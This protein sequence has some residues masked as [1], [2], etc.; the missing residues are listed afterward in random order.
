MNFYKKQK[1]LD[2]AC[3]IVF[4][5][6]LTIVL[7]LAYSLLSR[8][9]AYDERKYKAKEICLEI[10]SPDFDSCVNK[11]YFRIKRSRE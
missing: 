11:E 10:D 2:T 5:S 1:I 6:L 9:C 4:V 8:A 7:I 3:P